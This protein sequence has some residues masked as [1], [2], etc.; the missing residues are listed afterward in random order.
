MRRGRTHVR[1]TVMLLQ[2]QPKGAT[3]V[4]CC[5]FGEFRSE[6]DV[7]SKFDAAVLALRGASHL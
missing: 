6:F 4:P 5:A 3:H 7:G 2:W 1:E